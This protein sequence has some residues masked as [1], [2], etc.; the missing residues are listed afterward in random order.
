LKEQD[1]Q[2]QEQEQMDSSWKLGLRQ[3]AGPFGRSQ[4]QQ[5]AASQQRQQ[6]Q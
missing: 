6:Q 2:L 4:Q 3:P 1:E 5:V